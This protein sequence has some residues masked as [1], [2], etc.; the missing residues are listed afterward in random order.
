MKNGKQTPFLT[1]Y[2]SGTGAEDRTEER[3]LARDVCRYS[4]RLRFLISV[5]RTLQPEKG[6][7]RVFLDDT[8]DVLWFPMTRD[9]LAEDHDTVRFSVSVPARVLCAEGEESALLYYR[10]EMETAEGHC[11]FSKEPEGFAPVL[12]FRDENIHAFQLTVT[13]DGYDT[14][15][16]IRGG[17]MYHIFVDRFFCGKAP[18]GSLPPHRADAVC[19]DDWYHGLPQHA[20]MPGGEVENNE[21]FGGN[22]WGVIEKLPYLAS[23]G[24][25]I[26][27]LSPIFTAY[28]N[29]KYDTG[30]YESVDPG[31]GGDAVLAAL[32]REARTYGIRVICDGVFNHTGDD[33]RY[34]NR[35]GKYPGIG[36]YQS[37]GSPYYPWYRFKRYPDIYDCW[38]GVKVLPAV[39]S[40]NADFREYVCGEEGIL[41]RWMAM[42]VS[43]WR[44]DV[45]DELDERFLCDLRTRVR[46]ENPAAVVYGE[47]WEDA[48]NKISYGKRR[49]YFRGRQLDSVMNYPFRDGIIAFLRDGNAQALA[50]AAETVVRHYPDGTVSALMNLIGTHDTER[51]LTALAADPAGKLDN[52]ALAE[53]HMTDA[54]YAEGKRLVML[55]ALLQYTLPGIPCVYYGDEAGMEGYRDPFNRRPY[56]WGREDPELTAWYRKLGSLRRQYRSRLSGADYALAEAAHGVFAFRRGM[57]R[58]TVLV[59]VNR[60]KV[61]YEIPGAWYDVLTDIA[62]PA[63]V[64][65]LPRTGVWLTLL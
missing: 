36:A 56:P 19:N 40:G 5:P 38:W 22:L 63:G 20:K 58:E 52:D 6:R 12:R 15:A 29:H 39:D 57:G 43:G 26:L 37:K 7:M 21:F 30:D 65:V 46:K 62:H 10:F 8:G 41:H 11:I 27:Y 34:F 16:D 25:D 17:I 53:K 59:C 60:G 18:D 4:D 33:S 28:S 61:P 64:T 55:A 35:R 48:S 32:L 54:Q 42:G 31:F 9:L 44:L 49:R 3:V 51:I 2:L 24:V 14:P 47:V 23:L 13:E 1:V 50:D 45:A